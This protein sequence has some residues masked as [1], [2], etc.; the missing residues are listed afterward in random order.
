[1]QAR[2]EPPLI[3]QLMND[4]AGGSEDE[5]STSGRRLSLEKVWFYQMFYESVVALSSLGQ[6]KQI[7]K[8]IIQ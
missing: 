2:A 5:I 6:S 8:L 3:Y 7:R 4:D 1:M